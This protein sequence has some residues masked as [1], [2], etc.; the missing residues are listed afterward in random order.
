MIEFVNK[1]ELNYHR[2]QTNITVRGENYKGKFIFSMMGF[3]SF[4]IDW[5][6]MF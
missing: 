1:L 4:E 3:V 5:K 6:S 2:Y